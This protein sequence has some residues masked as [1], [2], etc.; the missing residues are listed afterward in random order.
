MSQEK[1][2]Q[3]KGRLAQGPNTLTKEEV[4]WLVKRVE[5]LE[6]ENEWMRN[7]LSY[8]ENQGEISF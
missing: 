6:K 4:E 8:L 1:L 5:D 3:I 7:E 2:S